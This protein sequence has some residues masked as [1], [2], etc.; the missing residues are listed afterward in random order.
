LDAA[1][2]AAMERVTLSDLLGWFTHC[3]YRAQAA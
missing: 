1:I 3:G 2:A